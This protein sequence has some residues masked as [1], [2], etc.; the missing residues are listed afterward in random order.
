MGRGEISLPKEPWL[1]DLG[2][3]DE[4]EKLEVLAGAGALIQLS[5]HESLSIVVLEAWAQATPVIVHAGC[6][7]LAGQVERAQGGMPVADYQAFAGALDDLYRD[8]TAWHERGLNGR[9]Y[10][11]DR[12]ASPQDYVQRRIGAIEQ[13]HKPLAQQ[14]R[15]RGLQRAAVH[16]RT[17]GAA[18]RRIHR[19]CPDATRPARA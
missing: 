7:V 3:V 8:E 18:F 9:A 12:Y 15:K 13:M 14:M 2:R 4:A 17:S 16:A 19:K 6:A 11:A 10:V 5:C 1:R